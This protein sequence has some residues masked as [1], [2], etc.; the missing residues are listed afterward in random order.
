VSSVEDEFDEMYDDIKKW[1]T[2]EK[3][4][5]L[6]YGKGPLRRRCDEADF[7]AVGNMMDEAKTQKVGIETNDWLNK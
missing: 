3:A 6:K 5:I 7:I 4:L 2:M 1:K